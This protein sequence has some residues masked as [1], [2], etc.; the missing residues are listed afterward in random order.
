MFSGI[1]CGI[2]ESPLYVERI[3]EVSAIFPTGVWKHLTYERPKYIWQRQ[4]GRYCK[5]QRENTKKRC[6]EDEIDVSV[7]RDKCIAIQRCR[8]QEYIILPL[9]LLLSWPQYSK[10]VYTGSLCD[11]SFSLLQP[12]EWS[13]QSLLGFI[14]FFFFLLDWSRRS[15]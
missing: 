2:Y 11:F 9:S 8:R 10:R 15:D 13:E 14:S 3:S 6:K 1:K 12:S 4:R 7:E 5:K